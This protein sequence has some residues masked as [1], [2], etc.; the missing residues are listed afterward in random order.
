MK[1]TALIVAA[2]EG[3]RLGRGPKALLP[4]EGTTFLQRC[5]EGLLLPGVEDAVVVLGSEAERV[6][7]ACPLPQRVRLVVNPRWRDGMLSSVLVGLD[8]AQ[9]GAADAVLLHPVDSPFIAATTVANVV[10]ALEGGARVAVPSF[11]GRRGHPTGF[12]R[13]A[14]PA[15]RS[16]P[17][18]RG[19]RA[20]LQEHSEWVV[21]VE[22]DPGCLID[23]DTSADAL[24]PRR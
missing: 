11:Q 9:D 12:A 19:V 2:G 6:Q 3:R 18:E 21:H 4:I 7:G 8:A 14:W 10:A 22:G 13:D 17:P 5:I 15:L 16:A 1:V 20:V 23:V 24:P